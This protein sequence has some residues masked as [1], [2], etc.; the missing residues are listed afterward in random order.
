MDTK[1][2]LLKK[3]GQLLTLFQQTRASFGLGSKK[4]AKRINDGFMVLKEFDL[5]RRAKLMEISD[6]RR[7]SFL[8]CG[9]DPLANSL[10]NQYPT[11]VRY[12]NIEFRT[13]SSIHF[14][15]P[16][17]ACKHIIGLTIRD[18]DRGR[19]VVDKH[20]YNLMNASNLTGDHRRILHD[21]ATGVFFPFLRQAGI[22]YVGGKNNTA[23]NIFVHVLRDN[24]RER[25]LQGIIPDAIIKGEG[26]AQIVPD[27]IFSG[28]S[29]L[30][31][32]K[33]IGPMSYF[34]ERAEGHF[35]VNKRAE[36]VNREYYSHAR[37]LDTQFNNTEPNTIGPVQQIL[38][39][40]GANGKVVGLAIGTFAECS[41]DFHNLRKFVASVLADKDVLGTNITVGEV[42]GRIAKK[43]FAI[44]G[45]T[46]HRGWARLLLD[47]IS[48][49]LN[50][51]AQA[52]ETNDN[53]SENNLNHNGDHLNVDLDNFHNFT[54]LHFSQE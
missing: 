48:R 7:I 36:E 19:I 22:D 26:F 11:T 41:S 17:D 44:M 30:V 31:D 37:A 49:I 6:P 39:S 1:K 46:I 53:N 15:L 34:S 24:V 3:L 20:G 47:R 16:V 8:A 13:A 35:V 54:H 28:V 29:T 2:K 51:E 4:L 14:G 21:E 12:T 52:A 45:H 33:T 9:N 40:Y 42:K 43:F 50:R 32:T 5:K 38:R 23:K 27:S 25:H 10:L 18:A